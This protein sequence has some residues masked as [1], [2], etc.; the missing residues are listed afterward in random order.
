MANVYGDLL[1]INA[2]AEGI[3]M[4]I[5]CIFNSESFCS[6]DLRSSLLLLISTDVV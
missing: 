3:K 2:E 4:D 6:V 5:M 1:V